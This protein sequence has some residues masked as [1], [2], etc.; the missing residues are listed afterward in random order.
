MCRTRWACLINEPLGDVKREGN[1]YGL[2]VSWEGWR[3]ISLTS[4]VMATVPSAITETL[5]DL[6]N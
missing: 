1:E 6:I 5:L 2:G 4:L 3:G